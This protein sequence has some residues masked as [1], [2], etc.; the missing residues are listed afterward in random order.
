MQ[1]ATL[2]M[3]NHQF[4][5][6]SSNSESQLLKL[7]EKERGIERWRLEVR[8]ECVGVFSFKCI[9]LIH[10]KLGVWYLT[11]CVWMEIY[12]LQCMLLSF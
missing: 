3:K 1:E 2:E 9:M 5:Y 7:K 12:L 6:L 10:N 8:E 11:I 4:P